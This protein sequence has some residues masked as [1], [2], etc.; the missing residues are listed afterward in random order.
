M[1]WLV[2]ARTKNTQRAR[3]S[4]ANGVLLTFPFLIGIK[5]LQDQLNYG[6]AY[7]GNELYIAII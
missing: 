5:S 7:L 6:C 1:R 4:N 2:R 3:W